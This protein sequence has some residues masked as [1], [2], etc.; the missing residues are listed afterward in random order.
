MRRFLLPLLLLTVLICSA[1]FI[2]YLKQDSA[3]ALRAYGFIDVDESTLAF[4]ISGRIVSLNVNEGTVVRQGQVLATMDTKAIELERSAQ[5]AQCKML[6]AELEK[7]QGGY[8]FELI[9]AAKAEAARLQAA[10]SL[11]KLS[12]SRAQQLY[13]KRALSAQ[14]RDE[15]VYSKQQADAAWAQAKAQLQQYEHGY[16]KSDIT[17][18]DAELKACQAQLNLLSYR[19]NV[20]S[21]LTAPRDGIIR[22]RLQELGN[23]VTAQVPVFYLAPREEKTARFYVNELMLATLSVGSRVMLSNAAGD[24]AEAYISAIAD[25]A[26]FTPKTVQ[27]EEL[28]PD[29]VY[30]VRADFMDAPGAFRLG[31]AITVYLDADA[32][33]RQ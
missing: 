3:T 1:V 32:L 27:T 24:R 12:A 30:E 16:E 19:I 14:E 11:A 8:R 18:K 6:E 25:T 22:S 5:Q 29:L 7:L 20:Q 26:M 21:K 17:A 15:A 10:A 31:Q 13:A 28:R 9:A 4:D 23:Q 2:L 33:N